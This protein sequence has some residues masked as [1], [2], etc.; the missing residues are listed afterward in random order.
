MAPVHQNR[1]AGS[2]WF[3]G[4]ADASRSSGRIMTH[5]ASGGA[6]TAFDTTPITATVNLAP[7]TP[8]ETVAT[9][10]DDLGGTLVPDQPVAAPNT[11]ADTSEPADLD[12]A[13]LLRDQPTTDW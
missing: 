13:A 7:A 3:G 8:R 10:F 9:G 1:T 2:L 11:A 4:L 6:D 5:Q 12:A